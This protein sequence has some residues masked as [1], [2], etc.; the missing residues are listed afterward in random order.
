MLSIVPD[1]IP[2]T[3]EARLPTSFLHFLAETLSDGSIKDRSVAFK[4][5]TQWK[6]EQYKKTI[7]SLG[8]HPK[9]IFRNRDIEIYAHSAELVQK[10]VTL[11]AKA[12]GKKSIPSIIFS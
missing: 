4:V 1:K 5:R 12:N 9:V 11:G 6:A 10:L 7:E 3:A 2:I 8:I